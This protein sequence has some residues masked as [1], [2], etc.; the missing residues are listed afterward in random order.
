MNY[1]NYIRYLFDASTEYWKGVILKPQLTGLLH[2]FFRHYWRSI[3][4]AN[5]RTGRIVYANPSF[6]KGTGWKLRDFRAKA[7]ID[8]VH[9]EDKKSTLDLMSELKDGLTTTFFENRYIKPD[10]S[11]T[12]VSWVAF[13]SYGWYFAEAKFNEEC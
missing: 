7:F 12:K 5:A 4:F 6:L 13:V 10:G 9:D 8:F 2:V 11:F 3:V 1:V